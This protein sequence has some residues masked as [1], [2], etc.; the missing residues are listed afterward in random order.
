[1]INGALWRAD[2]TEDQ[3]VLSNFKELLPYLAGSVIIV[4]VVLWQH[5]LLLYPLAILST[6]GVMAML[7]IVNSMFVLIITRREGYAR[8]WHDIIL[9]MAMGL[10]MSFLMIGGMGWLRM[11]LTRAAGLPF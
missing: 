8:T 4:L 6:L 10:A 2:Y 1:V 3:P 7:G 9:P 11:A 5:P